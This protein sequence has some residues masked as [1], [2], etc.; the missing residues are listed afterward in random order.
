MK[1]SFFVNLTK[2][3]MLKRGSKSYNKRNPEA[4]Q[5][6]NSLMTD[7]IKRKPIIYFFLFQVL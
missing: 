3:K 1:I 2:K 5:I 4:K 7:A 6:K